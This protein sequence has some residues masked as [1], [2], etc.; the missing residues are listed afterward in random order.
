MLITTA[1]APARAPNATTLRGSSWF[2]RK[3]AE[4]GL[5]RGIGPQVA[6]HVARQLPCEQAIE[7][8]L[9]V[10]EVE[11]LLLQLVLAIPVRP[12]RG[13]RSGR[14]P[15][16]SGQNSVAGGAPRQVHALLPRLRE[17]V[18]QHQ[19]R[20]VAP[21]AVGV[22]RDRRSTPIIAVARRRVEVIQ[23]RD[24]GPRRKER[25]A[26]ARD[27]ADVAI[28]QLDR[29]ECGGRPTEA[30]ASPAMNQSG[31]SVTQGWSNRH[32]SG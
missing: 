26:A 7:Q 3:R 4:P 1:A 30:A 19:H 28:A 23:L 20:H 8:A 10:G 21:H 14:A 22:L 6:A 13:G 16:A 15:V 24:V 12:R 25:I 18:V 32:G 29:P 31:W 17:N 9:V 11:S 2:S 27:E 5:I